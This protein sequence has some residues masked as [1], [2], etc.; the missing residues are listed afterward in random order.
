MVSKKKRSL[1]N[2]LYV[3]HHTYSHNFHLRKDE[4]IKEEN[5]LN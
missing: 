4:I 5:N 2:A 3:S 1:R